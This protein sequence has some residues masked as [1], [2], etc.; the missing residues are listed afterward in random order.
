MTNNKENE[1]Y[2]KHEL[3]DVFFSM[4]YALSLLEFQPS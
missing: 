2:E 3:G 4:F 1:K